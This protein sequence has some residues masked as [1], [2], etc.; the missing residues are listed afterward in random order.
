[1]KTPLQPL[2]ALV[3]EDSEADAL[4]LIEALKRGG[5]EPDWQ[6]VETEA[7]LRAALRDR[8]WDVVFCDYSL[9]LF[10]APSA[11]RVLRET[12][13]TM[14][15][16]VVSGKVGEEVAVEAMRLGANDYILKHKLDG[17]VPAIERELRDSKLRRERQAAALALRQ[18]EER[19]RALFDKSPWPMWVYDPETFGFLAVNERAIEEYGYTREDYARMTMKDLRPPEDVAEWLT[20]F[21]GMKTNHEVLPPRTRRHLKKDGSV[22]VVEVVNQP[23]T[24]NGKPAR[25]VQAVDITTRMK[26]DEAL[27]LTEERFRQMAENSA[28]V[29]W[30]TD[31]AKKRILYVSPA[32]ETVWGRTCESLYAEPVAASVLDTIHP[33]DQQR[34]ERAFTA[35][36]T[37]R[38]DLT[39]RIIRPDG[40]LRWI[41]HRAYPVK[42]EG[43]ETYWLAGIAT[44]VTGTIE[45][46]KKIREQAA[47]LNEARDAICVTDLNQHILFW[48]KSAERL[49]GWTA[50]EAL[51]HDA[52]E[53]LGQESVALTALKTLIQHGEWRG[54]L[55]QTTHDGRQLTVD[56]RWTLIR[57]ADGTPKS[58]LVINTDITEAKHA[59]ELIREQAALLDH[60]QDAIVVLDLEGRISYWNR[61]AE[62]VFGWSAREALSSK[63]QDL[64]YA[65]PELYE[66][67]L[68][69]TLSL[70]SWIGE[71][72]KRA[73]DG[74]DM[75]IESR[76]T[77]LR[78][79]AE[80]ARAI[81]VIDTDI[82]EK[83]KTEAQFFRAQRMESI[84]TLAGG[85]AH[86][87]NNVLG[88][89]IMAVD[90]LKL[91]LT[92]PKECDLL[93]LMETSGRRGADMIKQILFF[94]RGSE[95]RR[96][97][98]DPA[99]LVTELQ[100][101]A[102]DTFAKSITVRAD[103]PAGIW[104]VPGDRTQ[105]H[106]VLLNLCVNA[107]DAMPRGGRLRLSL[108]NRQ[109]DDHFVAMCP[110]A[111]A[112]PYV[113]LAVADTGEGM[114]PEV[115]ARIF[116]PF[117]TTK[118][119]GKGTGLGLSTTQAIV[120]SH[121]G[122]IT[123]ESEP[124]KGTTFHVNL[125][126]EP[127]CAEVQAETVA[128]ELP[129]GAGE[130]ILIIDDEASIRSITGQTLEAFGYRVM[131]AGDGA[132]GVAKYAQHPG[133]I[134]A[135]LTDMMMP[136]MDGAAAIR[137]LLRLNP[138]VKIIAAS[139]NSMG[140]EATGAGA[141]SF[142]PKPY[143]AE[144]LLQLLHKLLHP[145]T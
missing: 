145:E 120:R 111:H 52:N 12:G 84:G 137:V 28:E 93:E 75:L 10:D 73:K 59:E 22:I 23:I 98:M 39:Y 44:D 45:A 100:R 122:F 2:R 114:A 16:I 34:V 41:H 6:R 113:V 9:P 66:T 119:I 96:V 118:E 3:V 26:T 85:I 57:E 127:G 144:S 142:L 107:R 109:I 141:K 103:T 117:F 7:A 58:I 64:L 61:S 90:L 68:K 42:N 134:A 86:D 24:C 48:N 5:Y 77:L 143:T 63:V 78:D 33:E 124:G 91:R 53:L 37:H 11:L 126:A 51:G 21:H 82:S 89:I 131:S 25:V 101:I 70:G 43:G 88:P 72:A 56:C 13:D 112:G 74:G 14:T 47:L 106:Q 80:K 115:L 32:Y 83:K 102:R 67:P 132:E 105:L 81:L 76:W 46:A 50:G 130:I 136:V 54:D 128:P 55:K 27:R 20:T 8:E 15:A 19:H 18:S 140:A 62:R 49:Y 29:F 79:E 1:M 123:V 97:L 110:E 65:S 4:L 38:L 121:G 94:A 71:T 133:E 31:P 40:T 35:P 99:L 138:A 129:R 108:R 36:I 69:A 17:V 87:L 125:P 92:D 135:V 139:G 95:G 104:N 60:A 116:E 30:M